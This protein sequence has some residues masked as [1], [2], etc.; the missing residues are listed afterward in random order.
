[1]I[2]AA[3]P[4]NEA[5]R[6]AALHRYDILDT[7]PEQDYDDF[8]LLA[9][10]ICGTP[11]A[12]ISLIDEERQWFKS[13][14]GLE[15]PET[16]RDIAFCAHA[17][18][19]PEH[20]FVVQ[21]P[22]KDDRFADNPLVT[23]DLHIRFYAGAPLVT[24]DNMPLGTLCVID[25][26]SRSLDAEQVKAL[27][28]LARQIAAQL[29]LRYVRKKLAEQNEALRQLN[30][31]KNQFYGMA[32]HDLRNPLQVIEGY[33]KLLLN[34][35]AGTVTPGQSKALEAVVNNCG[36]VLHLINDLLELSTLEGT[37]LTLNRVPTSLETLVE[38]N[39]SLNRLAAEAK[40]IRL[41]FR[42]EAG[43]PTVPVD[44]FRIDQVLNNLIS[45]AIK[46]SHPGSE[47]AIEVGR[48]EDGVRI[49]VR[50]QGQ[51]IP[52]A[53]LATLFQPFTKTSVRG[54]AGESSTGLGLYIVKR[55]VE[56]HG[57]KVEV[58]SA[59]GAGSAFRFWLP[60]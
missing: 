58:E 26:K 33:S 42:A 4:S 50:D 20:V 2:A 51:G 47:V 49:E 8:T 9:A 27:E 38:K 30:V 17:I 21:N 55:I 53:E 56:S 7:A 59:P 46:F 6:L 31:Q 48:R 54:T 32:A 10:Q 13:R 5:E 14:V 25:Q 15:A 3:L 57:G 39:V 1:M 12:L 28:A 11:I 29:E 43:I 35:V 41:N 18:L 19:E 22:E 23:G 44:T 52:A 34:G 37:A 24:P 45:N 40:K 36:F 60:S 16:S